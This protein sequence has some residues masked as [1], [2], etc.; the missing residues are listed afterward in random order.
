[1]TWFHKFS[2]LQNKNYLKLWQENALQILCW[3]F[4]LVGLDFFKTFAYF[5]F[6]F[7]KQIKKNKKTNIFVLAIYD[8][9]QIRYDNKTW[10][11][12]NFLCSKVFVLVFELVGLYFSFFLFRVLS[13]CRHF[14]DDFAVQLQKYAYL[15]TKLYMLLSSKQ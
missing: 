9:L 8:N 13:N 5:V 4:E 14:A 1:M 12:R 10:I 6:R 15:H 2:R 7:A 11:T 3:V